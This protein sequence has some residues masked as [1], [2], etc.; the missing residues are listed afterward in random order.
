MQLIL[1]TDIEGFAHEVGDPKYCKFGIF[2][3]K[4]KEDLKI[5]N[6]DLQKAWPPEAQHLIVVSIYSDPMEKK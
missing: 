4:I 5:V 1:K 3:D 6:W 2:N